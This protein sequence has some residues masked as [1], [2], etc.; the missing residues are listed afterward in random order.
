MTAGTVSIRVPA[1]TANLGP[2]FD[3]LGLALD[4]WNKCSFTLTGE[5]IKVNIIGEGKGRLPTNSRNMMARALLEAYRLQGKPAPAG[6]LIECDNAIPLGSGL[7][8]SAAA[9][10]AGLM[11]AN[12]FL[13]QPF[14]SHDILQIANKLEGHADNASA[15][16]YGGL[17]ASFSD[18]NSDIK[19]HKLDCA[20]ERVVVVLPDYRLPTVKARQAL[21]KQ[22]PMA[23]AV[24]NIGHTIITIE[25]LRSGHH[26]LLMRAMDDRLHQP[27]RLELIPGAEDAMKAARNL[28]APAALSGAGPSIIAFPKSN[29]DAVTAAMQ[30]AFT[31]AGLESRAWRLATTY[32]GIQWDYI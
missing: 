32:T 11:A 10:L 29:A 5:A 18:S 9:V 19:V 2:G 22:V 25:A 14:T 23:D 1:T 31:A 7:G 20:F 30:H 27:Y 24:F 16:L 13:G 3:C 8:S 26:D 4:L 15:A 17:T 21:P 28:G 12:A 6:L